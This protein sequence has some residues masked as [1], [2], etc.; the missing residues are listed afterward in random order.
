MAERKLVL[1]S[2]GRPRPQ[3]A[4]ADFGLGRAP[5][6]TSASRSANHASN[7]S[8]SDKSLGYYQKPL[9]GEILGP[10]THEKY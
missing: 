10:H 4:A 8:P 5:P 1:A 7:A 3:Q 6:I 2:G 9:R